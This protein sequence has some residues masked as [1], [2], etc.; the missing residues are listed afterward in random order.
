MKVYKRYEYT[1]P[2]GLRWTEWFVL[3]ECSSQEE[4]NAIIAE[5]QQLSSGR[6]QEYDVR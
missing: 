6:N 1:G 4:A 2:R 3:K 5:D